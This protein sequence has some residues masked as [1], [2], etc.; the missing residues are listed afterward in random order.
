MESEPPFEEAYKALLENS[1]E[2]EAK[3][4]NRGNQI[5]V[6]YEECELPLIDIGRLNMGELER[7]E[8]KKEM[9]RASQEWGFFQVINHGV[10]SKILED[11][12]SEQMQVFKQP[13]LLKTNHRYLNLVAGCYRW[14][15]PSATCLSQLS[16]SEAF[17]IPL[18][19]ISTSF[20]A[21]PT[22]LRY[23]INLL[24]FMI[25]FFCQI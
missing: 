25:E 19:D 24:T 7:K 8:C 17:H 20:A 11:M 14:G 6:M 1:I 23:I 10:S 2:D 3:M 21:L 16:W 15:T 4:S 12:R 22:S 9:A 18:S 13:F 5:G